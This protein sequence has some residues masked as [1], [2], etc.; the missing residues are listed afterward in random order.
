MLAPPAPGKRPEKLRFNLSLLFTDDHVEYS[1]QEART[2]SIGLL[3]KK[4]APLP[5]TNSSQPSSSATRDDPSTDVQMSTGLGPHRRKSIY[6]G[7]AEPTVTINTK[8]ALADV[9]GMYNSPDKTKFMG[10]PGSKHEPLK[11]IEPITPIAQPRFTSPTENSNSENV[12]RSRGENDLS[13]NFKT[14]TASEFR[15]CFFSLEESFIIANTFYSIPTFCR[16]KCQIQQGHP[17]FEQ[18]IAI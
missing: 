4:W 9:F 11:K 16:R 8:E 6:G 5:P 7:G 12:N 1:I 13:Q 3:G 15:I 14:P 18:G 17:C 2:R 10:I